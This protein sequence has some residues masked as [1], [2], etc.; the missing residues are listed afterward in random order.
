MNNLAKF[1]ALALSAA[2]L[3]ACGG[4]SSNSNSN[5]PATDARFEVRVTNLTNAQPLSP[6][7][8]IMHSSGF[9]NFID[10][11]RASVAVEML[12]EGGDNSQVLSEAEAA[13][14]TYIASAS[15]AGP[16]LPRSSTDT[17]LTLDVPASELADLRL[18]VMTM[19]VHTNDA[20]TGLNATDISDME[21]GSSRTF[22]APTWDAGTELDSELAGTLPGPDFGGEGFNA[23][24]D[25]R[26]DRVRFHNG[27]VTNADPTFGLPTSGL[28]EQHRFLNPS[29]RIVV[30]R[31]Q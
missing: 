2:V 27:A 16:V 30:T 28:E 19:L 13:T 11:E 12:A 10:G 26:I 14:A 17:P 3:T 20:F 25:D 5:T 15:T 8:V 18:S 6:V 9:N 7:A 21:V 22:N 4:S 29:S 23:A 31:V 24:R 1:A